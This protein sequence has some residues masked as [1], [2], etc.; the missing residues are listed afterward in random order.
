MNEYIIRGRVT[1]QVEMT[2]IYSRFTRGSVQVKKKV[3]GSLS[4]IN[5][6]TEKKCI[7]LLGD[8]QLVT[9]LI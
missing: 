1:F 7:G 3:H 6:R 9:F 2:T 5:K 4:L 8:A